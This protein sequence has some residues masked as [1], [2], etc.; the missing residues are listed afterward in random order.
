MHDLPSTQMNTDVCVICQ[1]FGNHKFDETTC[2]VA[3]IFDQRAVLIVNRIFEINLFDFGWLNQQNLI[4]TNAEMTIRQ[5]T[6]DLR[7]DFRKILR[8]AVHDNEII[9]CTLHFAKF[10]F[11]I[12]NLVLNQSILINTWQAFGARFKAFVHPQILSRILLNALLNERIHKA[13]GL[14]LITH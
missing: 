6:P 8:N 14:G 11:H 9:A 7:R 1:A 13:H 10:E 12:V 4:R 3:T 5:V 2:T